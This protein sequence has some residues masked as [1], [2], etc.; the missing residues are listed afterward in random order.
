MPQARVAA[1]WGRSPERTAAFVDRAFASAPS[2]RPR[3]HRSLEDFLADDAIDGVYIATP[4]DSHGW[5]ARACLN[6]GYAVLCEKPL[7]P[8]LA[9]SQALV[10]LARER[11]VFLMEALWTLFLPVYAQVASWLREGHIGALR[12]LESTFCFEAPYVANSRLFSL[13]LA[14]G[15]L[16]DIGIYNLAVTRFALR[17]AKG[18]CPRAI[19]MTAT[20]RR[21]PTGADCHV[22]GVLQFPDNVVSRFTC[23]F[24]QSADNRFRIVGTAGEITVNAGFWAASRATLSL[25]NGETF[26]AELPW[27]TNGFEYEIDEAMRCADQG[28]TE[29]MSMP[30]AESLALVGWMD[31]LRRQ[32][33]VRYPFER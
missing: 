5:L 13:D 24:D 22:D 25:R 21:A 6:Q 4:H 17:A 3:I 29:S 8:T 30:H 19:S 31:T 18:E 2:E 10:D 9:E 33:D 14:G 7:T 26:V 16:L 20:G 15:C 23:G 12:T 11:Q 27:R 32:L 1:I 28:C